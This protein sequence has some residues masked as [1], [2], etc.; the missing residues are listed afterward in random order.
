[1]THSKAGGV[2]GLALLGGLPAR[3][4][5]NGLAVARSGRFVVAAVGQE[6]RLGRWAR[7]AKAHNGL[8]MHRLDVAGTQ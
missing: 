6:P 5:V 2:S 1:M 3:G 7:D 8:L 4:W